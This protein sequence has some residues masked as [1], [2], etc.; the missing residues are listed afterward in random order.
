MTVDVIFVFHI[1]WY[2]YFENWTW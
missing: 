2:H 1:S